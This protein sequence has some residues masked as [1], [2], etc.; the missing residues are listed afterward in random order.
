[1]ASHYYKPRT[2]EIGQRLVT[3][4]NRTG[5]TQTELGQLIGVSRRSILKWEGG[6]G[7]PNGTHLQHLLEVFVDRKAFTAG[8]EFAEAETLWEVVSQ[9]ASKRLGQFNTAWFEQ[10]LAQRG[11][12]VRDQLPPSIPHPPSTIIDWGE[13]IDVPTLYGREAELTLLQQ[14]VLGDHCRVVAVLGLGGIGKTSLAL[15]F[16]QHMLS[17]FEVVLFRSLHNGPS[18]AE[19]L[20]QI[21]P[22]L[23]NQ[24]I[25]PLE[26]VPDKIA[27]L[28]QLLRER[29][30]LLILDNFEAILQPGTLTGTYRTGYADYGALLQALGERKHQSCLIVTS[31]EK[32][33]ALGSF[34]GPAG[35]V[36]TL[37]LT[38][39]DD[40]FC[41]II[42]QAKA[43]V[44]T[45]GDLNAL[46]RLYS[47]N[48]LALTLV[49]EPIS[50]LFDG[51]VG[52]FLATGDVFFNGVGALL[53]AQFA[54][55]TLLEQVI[56][57]WL[58]VERELVPL[59]ALLAD[60]GDHVPHREVLAALESLRHRMLIERAPNRPAFTL[61][62]VILEYITEQL[63]AAIQQ[64]IVAGRPQLLNRHALVQ[65]TAKE[66]VRHSQ[67]H[68]I[69]TPLLE[70]LVITCGSSS[71]V[72]KRL[73]T[74]L[75]SWRGQP[76]S[77]QGY[78]PG[79]VVNLL[80]LLRGH[81]RG[82]DLKNLAI[83]QAKLQGVDVQDTNLAGVVMQDTLFTE[84]FD[85][86]TAVAISSTGEFWAAASTRGEVLIWIAGGTTLHR[87]WQ[88]HTDMVWTLSF[89]PEGHTLASGSWDGGVK[90]WDVA[91][92]ALLW[93]RQHTGHVNRVAFAPDGGTLA[94]SGNDRT[95]RL[96]EPRNGAELETLVQPVPI[97][98][99]AWSPDGFL[100]ASGDVQGDIRLWR[101]QQQQAN[102]EQVLTGH[103]T[104]V[105]GL[106]FAPDGRTLAS[107]SWDGLIKLWD[108]ASGDLRQTFA[109]HTDQVSRVAWS[110]D[111]GTLASSSRD[112]T[113]RLWNVNDSSYRAVLRGHTAGAKGL[114]FT[115]DG[116]SLLSGGGDG[117]LRVWDVANGPCMRMLQGYA[118]ALDDVD[119]S[120]DGTWLVSGG[121]DGLVTIYTV[122]GS[123][124]PRVLPGH[125]GLV[126][127]VGWSPDGRWLASSEWDNVIRLW[128]PTSGACLEVLR[129][130][131]DPGNYFSGLAW[132]PDGQQLA[133]GTER[134]GVFVWD[135][136]ARATAWTVHAF[137]TWIRR[138]AWRPD[139]AQL[140]GGG[141]D[142][143]VYV[144]DARDGSLLRRMA[145]HHGMV[146][147]LAWSPDGMC[148]ASGSSGSE[149][150]EVF[151]W[152]TQRG[153]RVH[154]ITEQRETVYALAWGSN[155]EVIM[156]GADGVLRWWDVQRREYVRMRAAHQGRVQSLKRSP[157]GTR[158]A[159]CG[160]DG[161]IMLWDIHNGE[162]LQTLQRDR[163]YERMNITGLAGIS[164]AQR[165]S[166]IALGARHDLHL[167]D[168]GSAKSKVAQ[169]HRAENRHRTADARHEVM[170][171]PFQPTSFVGRSTE[172]GH[173]VR[174]L[175]DPAC[176]LLTLVGPGGIGKTRLALAVA[177]TQTDAFTDGIA[178]V[179]LASVNTLNQM[180]FAIGDTLAL[181]FT[182]HPNPT[183]HLLHHLRE[184]R[185]L[186]VLDNFEH[187]LHGAELV[188]NIL[189]HAPHVTILITS[190]ERLNL[191]P[192]WLFD[193]KG[194]HYPSNYSEQSVMLDDLAALANYSAVRLFLQRATQA[195]S[196]VTVSET[197]LAT[198]V[199]IC[200]HVAGMPLGIELAAASLR[201]L[202]L[203]KI[204][205]QLRTNLDILT[206]TL[207]DVPARHRS[208]RAVF[209]HSWNLLGD[210]ERVLFSHLAVFRGGWTAEAAFQVAGAT[211]AALSAL[212]DKSLVYQA[213][214][215]PRSSAQHTK[216]NAVDE[217]R[218]MML[219]PIR[220]YALERL[221][222][223]SD[224]VTIRQRH[225]HYFTT[226]AE[227]AAAE[228]NTPRIE[229]AVARLRREYDN[230]RAALQWAVDTGNGTHGLL[231]AQALWKFWRS[232]SYTSEGRAWL[233]QV[234][235]MD[236]HVVD[237]TAI[238]ARQHVLQ[239]AAWLAS[240][241]HDFETA[242]RLFEQSRALGNT[243]GQTKDEMDLLVN[244]ARQARVVGHYQQATEL[245]E[246]VLA[247]HRTSGDL[248]IMGEAEPE[249]SSDE[250]GLVLRELGLLLREQGYFERAAALFAEGVT[251][252]RA[253]GD[254][255][256][257]AFA[258]LGLADVA[259]DQG[260][261]TGVRK[262]VEPSLAIL[263]ELGIEWAIGFALNTF[264]LGA[265]Y[266][267]DVAHALTLIR[268]SVAIFRDLKAEGSLAEVLITLG[269]CLRAQDDAESAYTTLQE[270]LHFAWLAG[271]RLMVAPALEGLASI[272]VTQGD[273]KAAIRFLA[274]ASTLRR[275][276]G[277]PV[278][279]VDQVT[280]EQALATARSMLGD[281]AFTEIWA[282]GQALSLEQVLSTIPI[283]GSF[284]TLPDQTTS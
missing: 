109:G 127:A 237:G 261:V 62:P 256:S 180:V 33:A 124:D 185:I 187:L 20:D 148:L 254:R 56:L 66:Y 174:L 161:A 110:P 69:G 186:L 18:L 192:E 255:T 89:S 83:R 87:S 190:R 130:P 125:G 90:L 60:I 236:E 157:D 101:V 27:Q 274:N 211:H 45:A 122:S 213:S 63:V 262:Y 25:A 126:I 230:I 92:G 268:E 243:L 121:T 42:L 38:G 222:A 217:P 272:V 71:A 29:H 75:D 194:L 154:S 239:A 219:E 32:P 181:S 168:E 283:I 195:Q 23:S 54:R 250:L 259:R 265:Y 263:R 44:G 153:E 115:P 166:L 129:Y 223:R 281:I 85:A 158:L 134:H 173:I 76:P 9:A 252:H 1:M 198:I 113:I 152:D 142:G 34:E 175:G 73:Q 67:E 226:L 132:S 28:I 202:P 7:V 141:D 111:G 266:A 212:I 172:V 120:P 227:A 114:A 216:L 112:Q 103:A 179:G 128:D 40:S 133:A 228:W 123:T 251:L 6:E 2:Y 5:L 12:E 258:L 61:Q 233:E 177:A 149:G 52:A 55:S 282:E 13:A 65:A 116:G 246:D 159:S 94:S 229:I 19:L 46:A 184:R 57:A 197:T 10:L 240:D 241:Q 260:D 138:V 36:R 225:A 106:D 271:P 16:G 43:M 267:G 220:Q 160:D 91:S 97:P 199:Q 273:A 269:K 11:I 178:F 170:G 119:W 182:G 215:E 206:T 70:R 86:I 146:T 275:Q 137:S 248:A 72:E 224:G 93:H 64:E 264:A 41:Q 140:A 143:A 84:T 35:P 88:A 144:W 210:E 77:D 276:M 107:A 3:L 234:L 278:W 104:W 188:S 17:H 245:L 98:A 8:Q 257:M 221:G 135:V 204:E 231:L 108:V 232:Y 193:V 96:W 164:E 131:N 50:E 183:A 163:P 253:S 147:C 80:R 201:A 117:T 59:S 244:A 22:T 78:G 207:R 30:C 24:Q 136:Q 208:M 48:P 26:R 156:S 105:D 31:R 209:E 277:T 21:I 214:T 74:L 51:D 151:V 218:F 102:C 150:G 205:Q 165:A 79:N 95:I 249:P 47:G 284:T 58:A 189:A 171:L 167:T 176:R 37:S 53:Q 82:L 191:Q 118:V 81:L 280:T 15:I 203:A 235:A 99:I 270:A 39:L 4:R 242:T 68:L 200:Q 49:T 100:L 169:S 14:W 155:E 279:P 162:H 145:G 238:A 139:G 247:W 196:E